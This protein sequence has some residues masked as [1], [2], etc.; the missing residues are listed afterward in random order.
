MINETEIRNVT[1][2]KNKILSVKD[3]HDFCQRQGKIDIFT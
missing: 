1:Y 3:C 2:L